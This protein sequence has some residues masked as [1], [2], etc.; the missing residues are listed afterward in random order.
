M[1]TAYILARSG[2]ENPSRALSAEQAQ[3]LFTRLTALTARGPDQ[4]ARLFG[5]G[6]YS[7]QWEGEAG[8]EY[9][10]ARNGL[11]VVFG[12]SVGPVTFRDTVGLSDFVRTCLRAEIED[13]SRPSDAP[14][15]S[16][17]R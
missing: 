15:P 2:P 17:S 13:L 1:A 16:A 5:L 12:R 4:G 9:L 3:E 7:V 8:P 10:I 14:P 6:G 11:V